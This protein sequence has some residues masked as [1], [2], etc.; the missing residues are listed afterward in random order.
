MDDIALLKKIP[1]VNPANTATLVTLK[2]WE[3]AD[4]RLHTQPGSGNYWTPAHS[5]GLC[6]LH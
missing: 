1:D 2:M 3:I 6:A 4:P 5:P